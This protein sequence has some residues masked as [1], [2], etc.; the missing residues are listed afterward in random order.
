MAWRWDWQDFNTN[1]SYL[2]DCCRRSVRRCATLGFCVTRST[3]KPL[4]TV[5]LAAA[6]AAAQP[7]QAAELKIAT[8]NLG[9]HLDSELARSWI[10]ACSQPFALDGADQVWKPKPPTT[11]PATTA[12]ATLT[13]WQLRW[14]RNAPVAWDIAQLP[15]CDVFQAGGAVLAVSES[16]YARRQQQIATLLAQRVDADIIAFQ[17]VSGAASVRQVLPGGG[18]GWEVCS[19]EGHKVQRL[20]IAWKSGLGRL[21]SCEAHWPLSLPERAA[22]DQPRPGLALTLEVG[23][24]LLRVLTVHLKSSCVSPLEDPRPNGRG[25]LDGN[26][27]NC[28]VLQAQLPAL[29]GWLE[30]QATRDRPDALVLL[31]DFNRNLGHE[32]TEPATLPVRSEGQASDAHRPG[33]RSRSLWREVNDG[34]PEASTL[35]LVPSQCPGSEAVQALCRKAG[36]QRIARDE[37]AQIAAPTALGC[38]NPIGL[39]YITLGGSARALAPADKV[40]LGALGLSSAPAAGQ[41]DAVLALSDHCPLLLRLDIGS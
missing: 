3:M 26:E 33:Q 38:R 39:D 34:V 23:G 14:G 10:G 40:A 27:A 16:A 29:E 1:D 6:L 31:G 15:P 41:A 9:W 21:R 11:A 8:W 12:P 22:K 2:Q 37:M 28:E 25:Q 4:T 35:R 36:T 30:E 13:G 19:Y 24:K 32:A 7:V 18:Q 5:L 17:E 20:A